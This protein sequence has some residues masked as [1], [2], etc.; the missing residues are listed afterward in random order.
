MAKEEKKTPVKKQRKSSLF[1]L[2]EKMTPVLLVLIIGLAFVVGILWQKVTNLE[3]GGTK[4]VAGS[5]TDTGTNTGDAGTNTAPA[6]GKLSADQAKKIPAVTDKDHIRG[7]SDAQVY[8]IEYSD[9]QCPFC[10]RFHPTTQQ[11]LQE[12]GDKVALVY[13]HFPLDTLHPQARPAALASECV[14]EMGG[15][16]AFWK[17]VDTVFGDQTTLSDI[18]G[19]A[20]KQGYDVGSCLDS[21]K[22][23][24]VVQS[25]Y[26]GGS[27]AGVTGTPGNFVVNKKGDAWLIPG[28][29]PFESVKQVI[30]EAL[31]S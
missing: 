31:K 9:F 8:L 26:D 28:A 23:A 1:G 18:K 20:S 22:Y 2:L 19:I 10:G 5:G 27:K 11:I 30:D 15:A 29:V 3:S 6:N 21:K 17:F 13:R 14:F 25:D 24:D 12:Y 4:V 7:A 16:D